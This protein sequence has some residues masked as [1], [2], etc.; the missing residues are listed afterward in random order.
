MKLYFQMNQFLARL[1]KLEEENA[2]LKAEVIDL[3]KD[4][5]KIRSAHDELNMTLKEMVWKSNAGLFLK[6]LF[7]T[8]FLTI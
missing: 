7:Y 6:F 5:G 4:Y 2:N 8:I 1:A 3:R